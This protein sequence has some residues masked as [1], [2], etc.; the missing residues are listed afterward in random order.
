[1]D[2]TVDYDSNMTSGREGDGISG[3]GSLLP[4]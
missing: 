3:S 2:V 1:M 4:D